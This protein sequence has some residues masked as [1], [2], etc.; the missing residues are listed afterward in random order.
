MGNPRFFEGGVAG[1]DD[2]PSFIE[3]FPHGIYRVSL[4]EASAQYEVAKEGY[5]SHA[6]AGV[7]IGVTEA[8]GAVL[9]D[10]QL[11]GVHF[12]CRAPGMNVA[13]GCRGDNQPVAG[14]DAVALR[15]EPVGQ[16]H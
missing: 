11:E 9:A 5:P 14:A 2:Q 7:S 4:L 10:G 1:S 3:A 6:G 15:E 8:P 16:P 12:R 13:F